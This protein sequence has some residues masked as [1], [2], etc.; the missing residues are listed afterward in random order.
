MFWTNYALSAHSSARIV[1]QGVFLGLGSLP[2]PML[3]PQLVRAPSPVMG[4]AGGIMGL[5]QEVEETPRIPNPIHMEAEA[6]FL[7]EDALD[8]IESLEADRPIEPIHEEIF[9]EV[10][11]LALGD[12]LH[13]EGGEF[14]I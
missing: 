10:L 8:R 13:D 14:F 5:D 3:F 7:K 11:A 2:A 4:E 12:M 6:T 1:L 9:P